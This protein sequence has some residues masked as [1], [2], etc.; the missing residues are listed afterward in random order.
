MVPIELAT[1]PSASFPSDSEPPFKMSR[2]EAT[3]PA[4]S[5]DAKADIEKHVRKLALENQA[6][7]PVKIWEKVK[8]EMGEKFP[9]G[10]HGHTH[11]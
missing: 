8:T 4:P 7:G 2:T 5:I 11:K 10:W 6:V 1:V 9:N 3:V